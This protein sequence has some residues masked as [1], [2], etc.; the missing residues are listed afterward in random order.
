MTSP[1][2]TPDRNL[3]A[4]D[5]KP[6][7]ARRFRHLGAAALLASLFASAIFI[8]GVRDA[9]YGDRGASASL[10]YFRSA[11]AVERVALSYD[12]LVADLYWIRAIQH[13]G[14]NR[15]AGGGDA[16]YPL[17]YPLLDITTTLDPRFV[18]A[19]RFG[20]I[21][22]AEA[23][24]GGPGRPDQAVALLQKGLAFDPGKWQYM[25]DIGFVYYWWLHDYRQAAAW[26]EKASNVPGAPWF[27]RSLAAVTHTEGGDR[28]RSRLLWQQ[29]R[30]TADNDWLRANADLRL[31]Q[32]DALDQIDELEH[33][34]REYR[35]R[36]GSLPESWD[37]IAR[38]GLFG[39]IPLDPSGKPYVLDPT[40]G[41]VTVSTDSAL[42]PL[43]TE[44][45]PQSARVP[46]A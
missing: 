19:Y 33:R 7:P 13:Y 1:A 14:G 23:F 45:L 29:L 46:D 10:L 43:P 44:P 40:T 26:F 37:A 15:L 27:L 16:K 32:L 28:S 9:R 24:P 39:G 12:A 30:E 36:F 5:W 17:L 25:Q 42:Y 22:L 41:E 8:G 18:V 2:G 3:S 21:F 6:R 11:R 35:A 34:V 4:E 20:A 38:A 31:V